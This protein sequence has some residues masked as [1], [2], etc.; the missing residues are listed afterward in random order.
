MLNKKRPWDIAETLQFLSFDIV[1]HLSAGTLPSNEEIRRWLDS[2]NNAAPNYWA[3][4]LVCED[5]VEDGVTE[6]RMQALK[7][8]LAHAQGQNEY[9]PRK[10]RW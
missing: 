2:I 6:A 8:A 5:L 1:N 9:W 7:N 4:E 3:L 10:D